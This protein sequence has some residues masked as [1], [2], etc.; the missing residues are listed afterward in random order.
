MI[1]IVLIAVMAILVWY[2]LA[3]LFR[4]LRTANIDWTGVTAAIA[5]IVLA[6]WLRHVTGMG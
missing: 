3:K 6:F 5:F 1:R 2:A 4:L